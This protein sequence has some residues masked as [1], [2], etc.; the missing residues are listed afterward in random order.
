M[1]SFDY[2]LRRFRVWVD[3]GAPD[4]LGLGHGAEWEC[5]YPHWAE[6]WDAARRHIE[7]SAELGEL[8]R[9]ELLYVL[10]RD[11]EDE[12]IAEMLSASPRIVE[13]LLPRP[14]RLGRPGRYAIT[15]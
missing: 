4:V 8:E 15:G 9:R 7:T 12:R 10:A 3:S 1:N 13:Q 2:E 14:N 11:N 6:L 5:N